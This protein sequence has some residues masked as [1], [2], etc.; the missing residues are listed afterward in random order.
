MNSK[1]AQLPLEQ[2]RLP[3]KQEDTMTDQGSRTSLKDA[4][5]ELDKACKALRALVSAK[6]G[7]TTLKDTL[8]LHN[9][10]MSALQKLNLEG[11]LQDLERQRT[12]LTQRRN[13]AFERRRQDLSRSA[14]EA[15]WTFRGLKNYDYVG[16]FQVNYKQ[17]SATV[18]LGSEK[19]VVFDEVDGT[20]LFS[21]LQQEKEKLDEFFFD[22]SSFFR[23]VK[24]A[25]SLAKAQGSDH[26]GKVPIRKLYPLVVLVRQ[27]QDDHFLKTP[28]R[29]NL[30]RIL[31]GS[32]RV[33]SGQ[34]R[35]RWMARRWRRA[36]G[37]P[38]AKHGVYWQR[39]DCDAPV[40]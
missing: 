22:R 30:H 28:G 13:D 26:D 37:K 25:I 8:A 38:N 17:E 16:C 11:I 24:E 29:E 10:A 7:E 40:T 34:V 27:S 20:R 15:G 9:K 3:L 12:E 1:Q 31:S 36:A 2:A 14:K 19:H 39:R 5:K 23:S 18:S 21:L 35:A 33:R 32:V 6:P 4:P